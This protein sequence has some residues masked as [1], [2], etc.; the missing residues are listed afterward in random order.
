MNRKPPTA[1]ADVQDYL[2]SDL[3]PRVVSQDTRGLRD[4]TPSEGSMQPQKPS[5]PLK[6]GEHVVGVVEVDLRCPSCLAAAH[7]LGNAARNIIELIAVQVNP[8]VPLLLMFGVEEIRNSIV[9]VAM[10]IGVIVVDVVV[11]QD[12]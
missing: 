12:T 10:Q 9:A 3:V 6:V 2:I 8:V 7:G 4:G 1:P 11:A 5:L